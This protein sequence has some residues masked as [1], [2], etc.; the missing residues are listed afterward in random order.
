D[1][2]DGVGGYG[3]PAGG[4]VVDSLLIAGLADREARAAARSLAALDDPE[5]T[6]DGADLPA[7]VSLLALLDLAEPTADALLS[8]WQ[9]S[10]Q[11]GRLAAPLARAEAGALVLDLVA[12][13]PHVLVAGTTGSGKSELLRTLVASL[14]SLAGP[15]D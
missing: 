11:G 13:G 5:A 15:D 10:S 14:A 2:P 7:D 1:G 4:F 3:G 9:V 12:D 8:R 6:V